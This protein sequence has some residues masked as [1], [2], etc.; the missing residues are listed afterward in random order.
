[1]IRLTA[2]PNRSR[3]HFIAGGTIKVF[4]DDEN[5]ND[6]GMNGVP[7]SVSPEGYS[8]APAAPGPS[9][10]AQEP[11]KMPEPD[12]KS[13][14]TPPNG[15]YEPWQEPVNRQA[16][17]QAPYTP[18][19]HGGT[20]TAYQRP[21]VVQQPPDKKKK[22]G[23]GWLAKAVCLVLICAVVSAGAT[24]GVI[25]LNNGTNTGHQVILGS[26]SGASAPSAAEGNNSSA[27]A[28]S[29]AAPSGTTT[30]L[31]TTGQVM[32]PEDI[33]TMATSQVVGV[34]SEA[35]T[36]VFGQASSSA[37]SGSGFIISADGY[38]VTNYHVISY[39]VER[40]YKLTVMM[41]DGKSY[42][43]K[44]IGYEQ[45]NDLAVVKIDAPGLNPVTFGS[46][47]EM[48]VGE[49]IYAVGN[50]LGELTYTMTSGIVSALDRAITEE[51]GSSVNMFQIDAAVNPG[52]SG[53]PVYNNKGEVIGIVSAKYASTGVEGLGFAIPIEDANVIVTQLISSGHVTGKPLLGVTVSTVTSAAAQY[54][55]MVE[56]AYVNTVASGSAAEKAGIKV[57]DII[58]KLG[59]TDVTS[60]ET[61]KAAMKAFKAGS[62]T[63]IVVNRQGQEQTL[64]ITF[65]EQGVTTAT[66]ENQNQNQP[67]FG[68]R[69]A[70]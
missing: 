41:H 63:S 29:P 66:A 49:Q 42:P 46:N 19:L 36:N 18:G 25:R 6:A 48:K 70:S 3:E 61:L 16:P 28:P 68:G 15:Y 5:R 43:A 4:N 58:I 34:N 55:R 51:D 22:N 33:Y 32:S 38:V 24:Y 65:D 9:G 56:G 11:P 1:M 52:N 40:G 69:S 35:K 62:T 27:A 8:G 45:D 14:P 39:A 30:N 53:G 21:P 37:V 54:Y 44:V 57:G 67:S 31:T 2:D 47:K 60:T 26:G 13:R 23:M 50:P 7:S 59:N 12:M 17:G 10:A 64:S 20:Y